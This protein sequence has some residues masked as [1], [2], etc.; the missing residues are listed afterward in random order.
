MLQID[1]Q[2][3]IDINVDKIN[4]IYES[5][6]QKD[7][8]L[9]FMNDEQI[10]EINHQHRGKNAPTDVL[11]FP[12]IDTPHAPLGTIL[13]SVDRALHVS[14][15]LNHNLEDEICLL[16]IHGYLHVNGY[17]H[18]TDNGEMRQKEEELIK[19]FNLPKSLIVRSFD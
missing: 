7:L 18:E 8:E 14:K 9:I 2:T 1:N 5:L 3:D 6:T 17:D 4:S 15:N 13:I 12:L 19:K 10:K 16:F 11:S